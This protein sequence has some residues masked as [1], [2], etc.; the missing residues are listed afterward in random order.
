[1]YRGKYRAD[2]P[3]AATAYADEVREII[4]QVQEGGGKVPG[5]GSANV[6]VEPPGC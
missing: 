2:H 1:M 3:D 4:Q 5:S 6:D